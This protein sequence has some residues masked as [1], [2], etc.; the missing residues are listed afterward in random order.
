MF[1]LLFAVH[2]TPLRF[3]TKIW[4]SCPHQ[5]LFLHGIRNYLE[6][7]PNPLKTLFARWSCAVSLQ[8]GRYYVDKTMRVHRINFGG[9]A[10]H[11]MIAIQSELLHFYICTPVTTVDK[12]FH[13]KTMLQKGRPIFLN[14]SENSTWFHGIWCNLFKVYTC[15]TPNKPVVTVKCPLRSPWVPLICCRVVPPGGSNAISQQE[16][17]RLENTNRVLCSDI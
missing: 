4:R 13:N 10:S 6:I 5:F 17:Q 14:I 8:P 9:P 16:T 7:V 1:I 2:H 11:K 3:I 12:Q 15:P